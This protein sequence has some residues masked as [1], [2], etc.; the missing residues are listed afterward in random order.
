ML[1][2]PKINHIIKTV[3]ALS[4]DLKYFVINVSMLCFFNFR[5]S[6]EFCKTT[7]IINSFQSD[8]K[9]IGKLEVK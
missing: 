2:K 9:R 8:S 4:N 3:E 5:Y 7:L 6:T 1:W